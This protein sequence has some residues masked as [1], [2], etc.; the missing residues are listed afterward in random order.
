M[1]TDADVTRLLGQPFLQRHCPY[2]GAALM[3]VVGAWHPEGGASAYVVLGCLGC[4]ATAN[5]GAP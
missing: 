5:G 3:R 4:H 1:A 2:C